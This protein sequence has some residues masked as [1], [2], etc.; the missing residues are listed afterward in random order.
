MPSTERSVCPHR[1]QEN[2][3]L[4]KLS[5]LVLQ[6]YAKSMSL[7]VVCSP[8]KGGTQKLTKTKSSHHGQT[9]MC[10]SPQPL[11]NADSTG[12]EGTFKSSKIS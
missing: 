12:M 1:V 4:G 11:Q 6:Q 7:T 2:K 3:T 5:P 8:G 9:E 10:A